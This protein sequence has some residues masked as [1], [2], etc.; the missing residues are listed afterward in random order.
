MVPSDPSSNLF[1]DRH[2]RPEPGLR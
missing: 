1:T 2:A